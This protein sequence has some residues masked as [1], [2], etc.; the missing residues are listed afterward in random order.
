MISAVISK[1]RLKAWHW[2]NKLRFMSS[3]AKDIDQPG[4]RPAGVPQKES[5]GE[6]FDRHART[7]FIAPAVTLILIFA[8]FPTFY[9]I[10]F[11]LSRVKFSG[12]GLKFRFVW[13]QNFAK[14]FIGNEQ[15][16]FLGKIADMNIIGWLLVAIV[17][18]ACAWWLFRSQRSGATWVG[19]IGRLISATGALFVAYLLGSTLFAGSQWGTLLNTLFYVIVGC[20]LQFV[21]GTGLAFLC[22]QPI[23]G[24]SFFR[25][26]FF[27]PL[28]ITP[29]GV[30]YA[31][32]MILDITKGPF[33]PVW[34]FVGLHD[35]AWSAS[36]WAARWF[37]VLGDSWQ[38][39]PFIFIC[40]LAALENV[41]RDHVE[42]AQVDGA[43]SI[44]IFREITW[45]QIVPVAATVILIRMIEAFK[46]VDLP[47]IMTGGGPGIATES[48]SLHSFF[49]WRANDY[50]S[51][52][53]IAYLLL[54]LTVIVCSSFFNYV[55]L[56]QLRKV[57]A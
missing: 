40:M 47:N 4:L 56:K 31:F 9:S 8:I 20:S 55:V 13:L 35:W 36:A 22:S 37:I 7:F 48:M 34:E 17:V 43:S 33:R 29:L 44:Q 46:I 50:G 27:I 49:M 28:M 15:V 16:H 14:Q 30:G 21:I 51:S 45:P 25:V 42:A 11:A 26:I 2:A 53:A 57:H 39:I 23:A 18:A 12:E 52:A 10:V 41:P 5:W 19:M 32:K 54:I 38:W 6:W 24:K 1:S 3:S